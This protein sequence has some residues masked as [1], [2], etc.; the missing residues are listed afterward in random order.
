VKGL[1]PHQRGIVFVEFLIAFTPFFL[2][3]LGTVQLA[4]LAQAHLIVQHA[5]LRAARTAVITIDDDPYFYAM[6]ARKMLKTRDKPKADPPPAEG[7]LNSVSASGQSSKVEGAEE[8]GGD[9]LKR[10][11][12][13]AYLPL[14]VISPTRQQVARWIPFAASI[15]PALSDR[16]LAAATGNEPFWRVITGFGVYSRAASAI[17]FPEEPGSASLLD[18]DSQAFADASTV[19]T[20]VTFL[21]PCMVPIVRSL[22]CMNAVDM[23]GLPGPIR[24]TLDGLE[25]PSYESLEKVCRQ[26]RYSFPQQFRKF[27][28][29][30]NEL[31][32]A[33]WPVL[34]LGIVAHLDEKFVIITKEATLPNH[35]APYKYYSE[36]KAEKDK[37]GAAQ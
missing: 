10:I 5:A 29:G 35:G 23:T 1:L 26:W 27:M 30:L 22:I 34:L 12:T 19:T 33:E 16:S 7:A 37:Q 20:R 24:A 17:T 14:S 13:A 2:L 28:R 21:Y 3:F 11:R 32:N 36:I 15:N 31:R 25:N 8:K 9:R 18:T 6:E 4:F